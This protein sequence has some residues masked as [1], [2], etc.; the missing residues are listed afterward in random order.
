MPCSWIK[1]P[2]GTVAHVRH[3]KARAPKCKFCLQSGVSPRYAG[4]ATLLCDFVVGKTLGG[5]EITCDARMCSFCARR[6]GPDRD[7]CPKH[8]A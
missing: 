6:V 4:E 2:D 8:S 1:L 3:A 5:A 7:F